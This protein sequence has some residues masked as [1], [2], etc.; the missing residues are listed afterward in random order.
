[1]QIL[2]AVHV[3]VAKRARL[4]AV[5]AALL[6][7]GAAIVV[8]VASDSGKGSTAN[9]AADTTAP[10]PAAAPDPEA[11]EHAHD[12]NIY[13]MNLH[14]RRTKRVTEG[15]IAQQPSWAPNKRITFSAADCD[16]ACFSQL[17]Y[18]DRKGFNQ[19]LVPANAK[20]HFFSPTWAPGGRQIAAVGLGRGIFAVTPGRHKVR[21]LTRN[22]SDEAPDWSPRGDSVVFDRRVKGTNYDLFAV[23][24]ATRKI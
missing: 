18:V 20:H 11:E 4:A 12:S 22:Q 14:S 17:F 21:R 9:T 5:A 8:S 15:Q 16:D 10:P 7:I 2:A 23:N 1:M 6:L 13:V 3:A 19:V 24:P